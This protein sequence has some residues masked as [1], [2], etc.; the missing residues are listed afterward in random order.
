MKIGVIGAGAIGGL[1]A[2]KLSVAGE[3]V[4]VIARGAHLEAILANGLILIEE[5]KKVVANVI[6]SDKITDLG[7]QD[8][9]ILGMKAHQIAASVRDLAAILGPKTT[10][11]TAQNGIPWWYFHKH[12]GV[13]EGM[14]LESVDPDGVIAEHLSI[15]RVLASVVYPA[16]TIE[17]PGI[18]R[19]IEGNRFS[20]GELDGQKTD[21][22][23][24]VSET[25]IRAGFKAPVINDVRAE[26]WTKL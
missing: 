1:L 23:L 2:T 6:A 25:F 19:H 7:Q 10:V 24:R 17:S 15:D 18:I 4:K 22:V 20:I 3:E 9:I 16:A 11:L 8:L 5:D 13:H 21:R 14:R 12:G 26:I